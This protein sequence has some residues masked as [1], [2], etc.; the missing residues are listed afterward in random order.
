MAAAWL[1]STLLLSN[2]P[3]ERFDSR[4]AQNNAAQSVPP[5]LLVMTT[6]SR[7]FNALVQF[8]QSGLGVSAGNTGQRLALP[9]DNE[10]SGITAATA[11]SMRGA[12][13]G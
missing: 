13:G 6:S 5:A 4:W 2:H 3:A 9:L 12:G 8:N 11:V 10:E 7:M 1:V